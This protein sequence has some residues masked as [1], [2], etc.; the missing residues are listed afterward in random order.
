VSTDY[1]SLVAG[2]V[3]IHSSSSDLLAMAVQEVVSHT[4]IRSVDITLDARSASIERDVISICMRLLPGWSEIGTEV[5]VTT[6]PSPNMLN[7]RC[8]RHEPRVCIE[9]SRFMSRF[10]SKAASP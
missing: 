10:R 9:E 4:S 8:L 1:S 7:I 3:G 5:K 6:L 2:I